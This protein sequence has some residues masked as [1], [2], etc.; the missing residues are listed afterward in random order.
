MNHEMVTVL[1]EIYTILDKSQYILIVEST[2]NVEIDFRL[3]KQLVTVRNIIRGDD[4]SEG[5]IIYITGN[6][7]FFFED[8]SMNMGFVNYMKEGEQYLVFLCERLDN[9]RPL[10]NP[11]LYTELSVSPI[12]ELSDSENIIPTESQLL[13][14][15]ESMLPSVMYADV[16]GNEFF[17]DCID[18]LEIVLQFKRSVLDRF[19]VL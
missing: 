5:D 7:L 8:M 3:N 11:V 17:V 14:V 1:P 15:H 10:K 6:Y 16:S 9:L 13:E 19:L 4:L 12:F 2:G 18:V